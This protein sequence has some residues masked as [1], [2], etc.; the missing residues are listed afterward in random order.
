MCTASGA[1]LQ[2][3]YFNL[4]LANHSFAGLL[5]IISTLS[6]SNGW[7]SIE[8]WQIGWKN[9]WWV[10]INIIHDEEPFSHPFIHFV[11]CLSCRECCRAVYSSWLRTEGRLRWGQSI[12]GHLLARLY[13]SIYPLI[14][15]SS[16]GSQALLEFIPAV[17]RYTLNSLWANR[18]AHIND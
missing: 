6:K 15:L 17:F 13:L 16:P 3:A 2:G 1:F 7:A 14:R 9:Q 8:I 12:W 5:D 10:H 18:R 4:G 11:K